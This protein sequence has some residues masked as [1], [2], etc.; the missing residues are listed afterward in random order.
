MCLAPLLLTT[1]PPCLPVISWHG[2]TGMARL[3]GGSTL[4]KCLSFQSATIS[5]SS[6][7]LNT[8]VPSHTMKQQHS[9]D[10]ESG[11]SLILCF[12]LFSGCL[13]TRLLEEGSC[14]SATSSVKVKAEEEARKFLSNIPYVCLAATWRKT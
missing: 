7:L 1:I 2:F 9:Q 11:L 12:L 6:F 14:L 8:F 5:I 10:S 13:W 3:R 4:V